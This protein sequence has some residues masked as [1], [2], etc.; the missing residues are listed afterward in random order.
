[1]MIRVHASEFGVRDFGVMKLD[2]ML[3]VEPLL[4]HK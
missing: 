4:Y 2:T 3:S 1:M